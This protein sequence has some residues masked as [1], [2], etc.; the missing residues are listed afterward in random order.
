M[1]CTIFEK[2]GYGIIHI[3]SEK[4]GVYDFKIDFEDIFA[5]DDNKTYKYG[6]VTKQGGAYII[7]GKIIGCPHFCSSESK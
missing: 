6:V 7:N 5:V 4:F 3:E 1:S 2:D